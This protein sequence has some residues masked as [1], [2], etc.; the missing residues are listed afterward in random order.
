MYPHDLQ[1]IEEDNSAENNLNCADF[2]LRRLTL[3]IFVM[4]LYGSA[5]MPKCSASVSRAMLVI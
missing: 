3:C 2:V 5:L 1:D 4:T